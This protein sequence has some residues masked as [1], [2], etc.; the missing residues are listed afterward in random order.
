MK[1]L[2]AQGTN[3][4]TTVATPGYKPPAELGG[5]PPGRDGAFPMPAQDTG[6]S[7]ITALVLVAV[8]VFLAVIALFIFGRVSR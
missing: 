7:P 2:L 4:M 6:I 8:V 1:E 5:S 3:T